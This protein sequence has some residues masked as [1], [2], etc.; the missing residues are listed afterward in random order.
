MTTEAQKRARNKYNKEA[1]KRITFSLS[2]KYDEDIIEYLERAE[3]KQG[4][5][6]EALREKIKAE[7]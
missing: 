7:I 2:K 3:N 1:Y 6:K 5:I 4:V